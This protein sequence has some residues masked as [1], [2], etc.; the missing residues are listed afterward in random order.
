MESAACG[1]MHLSR[2]VIIFPGKL[3]KSTRIPCSF[4]RLWNS[5]SLTSNECRKNRSLSLEMCILRIC[6]RMMA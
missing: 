5:S 6:E 2:S 4:L 1:L 3:A